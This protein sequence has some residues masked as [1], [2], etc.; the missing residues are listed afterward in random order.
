MLRITNFRLTLLVLLLTIIGMN[1]NIA[2][3]QT[4]SKAPKKVKVTVDEFR[5]ISGNYEIESLKKIDH[6][7]E[8][9]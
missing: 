7:R 2:H 5:I 3:A 4:D 9:P 1:L 8:L 6:Y